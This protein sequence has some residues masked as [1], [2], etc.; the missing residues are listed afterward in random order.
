MT[1]HDMYT[2]RASMVLRQCVG[3]DKTRCSADPLTQDLEA[4]FKEAD[5]TALLE[6]FKKVS[7][8]SRC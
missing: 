6:L 1:Q 3:P 5:Q 4:L 7:A 8:C 2:Q